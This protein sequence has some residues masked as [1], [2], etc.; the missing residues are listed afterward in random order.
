VLA[1]D[2]DPDGN[3]LTA[4]AV[5]QPAHGQLTLNAS[6]SF[7][8]TPAAGYSGTDKFTYTAYDGV[9]HSAAATVTIAVTAPPQTDIVTILSA[10]YTAKRKLLAVTATSSAQPTAVLTVAGYGT[11]TYKTKSKSYVFQASTPTQ[12]ATVKV[13]SNLGGFD[14]KAVTRK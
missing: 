12:P 6:G 4:E 5:T 14:T 2:T 7:T 8:Y 10:T 13:E 3:T 11:M 9:V 1:N